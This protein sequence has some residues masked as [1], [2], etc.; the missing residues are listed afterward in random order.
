MNKHHI[1]TPISDDVIK[2]LRAGDCVYLSGVIYTARDAAHKRMTASAPAAAFADVTTNANTPAPH[3]VTAPASTNAPFDYS[4]NVVYY[5][6]PCPAPPNRPIG[7]VG[8]TTSQRMDTYTPQLLR[9][10]LRVM[11]GKGDRSETVIE[12]IKEQSGVYL[13]A[14]GGAGALISL[15]VKHAEI[16]AYEDL[17]PEAVYKLTVSEMPLIVAI[18]CTGNNIYKNQRETTKNND[19]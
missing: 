11:I 8:P 5:A 13:A 2:S 9:E 14:V 7:S 3:N 15:C 10:G 19:N 17:G 1:T 6:G 16:A 4:G 18:D 12:A